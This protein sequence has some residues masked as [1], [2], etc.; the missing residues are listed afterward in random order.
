MINF[1]IKINHEGDLVDIIWSDPAYVFLSSS[2][3]L[4]QH[5]EFTQWQLLENDIEKARQRHD[6][7]YSGIEYELKTQQVT[8]FLL[9][10]QLETHVMV[11]GY[12]VDKP[13]CRHTS[14]NQ[15]LLF[16]FL[17]TM[18]LLIDHQMQ[19]SDASKTNYYEKIQALNNDLINMQ[20]QLHKA[21]AKLNQVNQTLNNRLV[22]DALTGLISRYQFEDEIK[23]AIQ[24][25]PDAYGVFAFIDLDRFK[26]VN[27]TYGHQT[28]DEYLKAFASR[29]TFI[30]IPNLLKIRIAGDEF[31]L[32]AHGYT[33]EETEQVIEQIKTDIQHYV[34]NE[35]IIHDNHE[36][37]IQLSMGFA[38]YNLHS[39]NIY[40]L[41]DYADF[42][43]YQAK[44]AGK[45]CCRVFD[46]KQY[47]QFKLN[48][49]HD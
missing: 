13:L 8:V 4:F 30:S 9:L 6:V 39:D 7:S 14:S 33:I 34:I 41:I 35:P 29:L 32:Y 40:Q 12:Q 47:K 37:P 1:L 26:Q 25:A 5:I 42:A 11:L 43:M 10:I 44:K 21:N 48:Q 31:G 27:D 2:D 16:R 49:H 36:I 22:K 28:G 20:R 18:A 17:K 24:Q 3:N 46:L 19:F 23:Y 15:A 38:I 45:G